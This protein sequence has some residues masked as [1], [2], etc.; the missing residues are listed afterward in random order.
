MLGPSERR[1]LYWLCQSIGWGLYAVVNTMLINTYM[2]LPWTTNFGLLSYGAAGILVTH[3]LRA[4]IHR[5]SLLSKPWRTIAIHALFMIPLGA[6]TLTAL[7]QLCWYIVAG[8]TMSTTEVSLKSIVAGI[9]FNMMFLMLIWLLIYFTVHLIWRSIAQREAQLQALQAQINPHF[10]FNS[11]NSLR[12]LILENPA[13]AQDAVTRLSQLMRYSLTQSRRPTVPLSEEFDA[14]RDY[15]AI[16]KMRFEE[17][18]EVEWQ[19]E[20][21][22]NNIEVPPMCLQTLVENALKHGVG[23]VTIHASRTLGGLKLEVTNPG[24]LAPTKAPSTSTGLANV[25]ERLHLLRGPQAK[26]TL[27]ESAGQV[28]ATIELPTT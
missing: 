3:T 28:L 20:D 7:I 22:L 24:S 16:E 12:G 18:L 17:R 10:L 1:K 11:L 2:R 27:S 13:A 14:I 23:K 15:L 25:R 5:T 9:V 21:N 19:I 8:T 6:L 4:H 26:L